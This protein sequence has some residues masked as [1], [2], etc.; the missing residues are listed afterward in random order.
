MM[1]E[2]MTIGLLVMIDIIRVQTITLETTI[3]G[4][5]D[6]I[7]ILHSVIADATIAMTTIHHLANNGKVKDANRADTKVITVPVVKVRIHTINMVIE[8]RIA[9]YVC[10]TT[11]SSRTIMTNVKFSHM[12]GMARIQDKLLS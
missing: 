3:I 4:M 11:T 6:L 7:A 8:A 2:T 9:V 5:A 1:P 12:V 10:M